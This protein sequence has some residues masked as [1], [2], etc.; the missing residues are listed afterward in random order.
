MT[1]LII[2]GVLLALYLHFH[3]RHYRRHRRAGLTIRESIPGPFRTWITISR[4]FRE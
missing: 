3:G 2:I 4:R 1:A